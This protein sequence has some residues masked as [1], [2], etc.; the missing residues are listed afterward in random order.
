MNRL[1]PFT[2]E[3]IL[4][5]HHFDSSSPGGRLSTD[6]HNQ[7]SKNIIGRTAAEEEDT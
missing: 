5:L 3:K 1:T 2:Q 7:A 4:Y 6:I